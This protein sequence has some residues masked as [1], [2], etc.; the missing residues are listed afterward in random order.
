MNWQFLGDALWADGA[1][2]EALA[3]WQMG[4]I[5]ESDP[6]IDLGAELRRQLNQARLGAF[7]LSRL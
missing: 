7:A 2:E 3:A 1:E 6:S 5:A 4:A